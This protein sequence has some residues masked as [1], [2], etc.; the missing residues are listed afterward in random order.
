MNA[1]RLYSIK[2]SEP[3]KV[4][5]VGRVQTP[6]LAMVVQRELEIRNFKPENYW[7]IKT[8]YRDVTFNS[9]KGRYDNEEQ[10]KAVLEEIKAMPLEITDV[11]QKDGREAPPRLFD[12]T[13]LQVECNKRWGWTAE[14]SL[15]LIQR[16]YEKRSQHILE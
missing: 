2:Y 10:A 16:L 15:A 6:T 12:L 5:S 3:G 4:L 9:S 7:E 14:E 11:S 8:A 1:T 13:S